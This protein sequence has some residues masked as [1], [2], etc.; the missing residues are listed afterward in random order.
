MVLVNTFSPA[1]TNE[2]FDD[3]CSRCCH[4]HGCHYGGKRIDQFAKDYPVVNSLVGLYMANISALRHNALG[5][6]YKSMNLLVYVAAYPVAT[7]IL[8]WGVIRKRRRS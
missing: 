1:Y 4:D 2:C 6:S 5:Y 8:L 3:K 7:S